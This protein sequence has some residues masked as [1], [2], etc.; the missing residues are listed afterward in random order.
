MRSLNK[1]GIVLYLLHSSVMLFLTQTLWAFLCVAR[2]L[3]DGEN[4]LTGFTGVCVSVEQ[5][6]VRVCVCVCVSWSGACALLRGG[7]FDYVDWE[8]SVKLCSKCS[9][10]I[11]L[12]HR[13][14]WRW[15]DFS[16]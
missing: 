2:I 10:V 15:G 14:H 8:T 7:S 9:Y 11:S 6:C 16:F 4:Q 12:N 5:V 3:T 13:L 1:T